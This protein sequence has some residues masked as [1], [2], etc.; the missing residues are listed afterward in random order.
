MEF[1]VTIEIPRGSRN[2]YEIDHDSGRLK[3]DRRLFTSMG[4]PA[5]YGYIDDTLGE[6]SD[7]LD[8]IVLLKESVVPGCLVHAR[9]VAVFRMTDEMG[10]DEKILCVLAGDPRED[11]IQDLG[12][13]DQFVLD[14][15]QHFFENYKVLEPGKG[16]EV[17]T[18]WESRSVA[19]RFVAEARARAGEAT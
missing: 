16:V 9:P 14:E 19:E 6:D 8:A 11:G 13:V 18:R 10:S 1:D 4:Y 3:L 17:G 5:D 15:I 12:D 2:K 7:P